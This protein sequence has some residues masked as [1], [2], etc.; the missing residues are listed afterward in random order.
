M[1]DKF[2]KS[3]LYSSLLNGKYRKMLTNIIIEHLKEDGDTII[4]ITMMKMMDR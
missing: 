4:I 1:A 2:P 3:V